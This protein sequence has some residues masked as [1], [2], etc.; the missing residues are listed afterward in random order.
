[1]G[2]PVEPLLLGSQIESFI[3]FIGPISSIFNDATFFVM[4]Q[5]FDW[6]YSRSLFH[7]TWFVELL[8]TQTLTHHV[9]LHQPNPVYRKLGE[10]AVDT[11][12]GAHRGTWQALSV[13]CRYRRVTGS[14]LAVIMLGYAVLTQLTTAWFIGR[15]GD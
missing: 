7:T 14:L 2:V 9:I 13:L 5:V 1:M 10:L 11:Y 6:W 4:V 15:F 12:L 3:L 8:F